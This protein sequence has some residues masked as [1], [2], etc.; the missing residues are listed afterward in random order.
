MGFYIRQYVVKTKLRY[1]YIQHFKHDNTRIDPTAAYRNNMQGIYTLK[2]GVPGITLN[3]KI[4][5][6]TDT[7]SIY[8]VTY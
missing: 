4:A 6:Q 5:S 1:M 3:S 7:C 8:L 2:K